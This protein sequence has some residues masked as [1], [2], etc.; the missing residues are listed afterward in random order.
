MTSEDWKDLGLNVDCLDEREEGGTGGLSA[1][2]LALGKQDEE[3]AR[4]LIGWGARLPQ[5]TENLVG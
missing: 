2:E 3:A 1:L 4:T 5:G